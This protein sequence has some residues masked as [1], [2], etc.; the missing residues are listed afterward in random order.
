MAL[1]LFVVS[2][3]LGLCVVVAFSMFIYI[4]AFYTVSTMGIRM[5]AVN[6]LGFLSG[7]LIPIPFFPDSVRKLIELLPF[8][9]IQSAPFMIYSGYKSGYDAL[10]TV[11]LQIFW[12]VIMVAAGK[13]LASKAMKRVVVQGG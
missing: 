13:L 12:L 6:L 10:F 11:L 2:M 5:I 7:E 4:S 3:L 9:S 8:A 1:I